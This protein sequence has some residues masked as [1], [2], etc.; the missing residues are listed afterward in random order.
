MRSWILYFALVSP[1][2][3]QHHDPFAGSGCTCD[4]F[5]NNECSIFP[6]KPANMTLR[7]LLRHLEEDVG[8]PMSGGSKL[9]WFSG[10]DANSTDIIVSLDIEVDGEWGPY[11]Y[12]N[13]LNSSNEVKG[14]GTKTAPQC[15]ADNFTVFSNYC[16]SGS[17]QWTFTEDNTCEIYKKAF[18]PTPCTGG[19][20]GYHESGPPACNCSRVH[21]TVGRE[22]LTSSSGHGHYP[23]GGEWFSHPVE[24]ECVDGHYVGDGS[25]CTW[26]VV[27]RN[28]I[29]NATCMYKHLD[30]NVES[31][32]PSCFSACPQPN[33]VTSTCYLKCYSDASSQ[34]TQD[35]LA[36]PWDKAFALN[37]TAAGGCPVA[38][39]P[40]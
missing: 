26:R 24:G 25:G 23:A 34:M 11:M 40:F 17:D 8:I 20:S 22:N 14:S 6:T 13:P 21:K 36:A 12:C 9:I 7:C 37:E 10:D 31:Y 35:E 30:Q 19:I 3:S 16:W 29:I 5:C 28:K 4:T 1:V 32:D 15:K 38:L 39:H 27:G 2:Y 33:N 18:Y